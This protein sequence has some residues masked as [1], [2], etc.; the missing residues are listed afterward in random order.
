M[1]KRLDHLP[2]GK[3]HELKFVVEVVREGFAEAVAHR[4]APRF[5]KGRI[6]KIIF[7][8]SYARGDWV[9]DPVGRYFS[10][11]DLRVVSGPPAPESDGADAS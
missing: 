4:T 7:F 6:L 5:R 8:G 10:D 11:Y 9:E 3:R 2:A 1:K